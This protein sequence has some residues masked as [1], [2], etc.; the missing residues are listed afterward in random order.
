MFTDSPE[1]LVARARRFSQDGKIALDDKTTMPI[2]AKVCILLTDLS[3]AL[4]IERRSRASQFAS[5]RESNMAMVDLE[6]AVKKARR[7]NLFSLFLIV[8]LVVANSI[9]IAHR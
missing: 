7:L 2:P 6:T 5:V 3:R 8:V 4:E 9:L 1:D